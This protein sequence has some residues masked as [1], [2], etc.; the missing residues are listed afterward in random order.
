MGTLGS[1]KPRQSLERAAVR[2]TSFDLLSPGRSCT[3]RVLGEYGGMR[4]QGETAAT[5]PEAAGGGGNRVVS[6]QPFPLPCRLP[7]HNLAC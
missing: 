3:F 5:L 2:V 4:M 6:A 7:G 1:L